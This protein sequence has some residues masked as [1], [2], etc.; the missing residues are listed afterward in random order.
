MRN[1]WHLSVKTDGTRC[2]GPNTLMMPSSKDCADS[3]VD[4]GGESKAF[5]E[6][7]NKVEARR[8]DQPSSAPT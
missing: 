6:Q 7:R 3:K 2:R 1:P 8:F 4:T 5:E